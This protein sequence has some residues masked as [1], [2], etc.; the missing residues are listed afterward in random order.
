MPRKLHIG[1]TVRT[2]GWEVLNAIPG[3]HV[4]HIGNANSLT[5]FPDGTFSELYAS[6]VV[7][8]LDYSGELAS[9]LMS[10]RNFMQPS[11]NEIC[12]CGSGL[13]F[14]KCCGNISSKSLIV[15]TPIPFSK[16]LPFQNCGNQD[17][18]D[19]FEIEILDL[20]QKGNL[21]KAEIILRNSL[22]NNSGNSRVLNFLG[23]IAAAVE[24][25]RFAI[26]YFSEALKY[27]PQWEMPRTNLNSVSGFL[28]KNEKHFTSDGQ[29]HK[30]NQSADK[31]L[32]IKA[33]GYGFWSDISHVL[34]QLLLAE[35]SGRTPIVHWGSNSLFWDGKASN[36]F[37]AYFEPVSDKSIHD[38]QTVDLSYWPPKW[39]RNN[40]I[41]EEINKWNGPYSR[42]A[43]LYMLG[44]QERVVVSDF[45][46]SVYDLKPWIP[47][48]SHLYGMS[49]DELF[50]YLIRKYLRPKKEILDAIDCFYDKHLSQCNFIAVHVRGSDKELEMRNLEQVNMEYKKIIDEALIEYDCQR[51]FLMTD[52]SRLK[53]YYADLYGVKLI[54]TFCQR[55]NNSTGIHYQANRDRR[56]LGVEVM[57]DAYI[58]ARAKVFVGNGFSNP[59]LIVGYLKDWKKTDLK[60]IGQN[61]YHMPNIF[62]H[63]W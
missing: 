35:L 54:T 12:P 25:P 38:I 40:L 11:R 43:G 5:N 17:T 52:D 45:H 42:I 7:E 50:K 10:E 28:K 15:S 53:D 39:N 58:A 21:P 13:K 46:T 31:F 29:P 18:L 57:V 4:D 49:V 24:L 56:S 2:V 33:W 48:G 60:L 62:I 30:E 41:K 16:L 8:H 32:L 3:P 14:K 59:S 22:E 19:I 26:H 61:M 37:D 63:N 47:A 55:T 23:W 6:H 51:I 36:A 34:A 9:K 20:I 44:R 27:S 1:G